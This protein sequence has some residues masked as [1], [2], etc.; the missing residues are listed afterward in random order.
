ME[1]ASFLLKKIK[2]ERSAPPLNG[3]P[4]KENNRYE[5]CSLNSLFGSTN[6]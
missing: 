6:K 4:H 2:K 5:E 3:T 1:R